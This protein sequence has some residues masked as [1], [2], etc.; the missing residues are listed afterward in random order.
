MNG[1]F[2]L[3]IVEA[4]PQG[5]EGGP[6]GIRCTNRAAT[7]GLGGVRLVGSADRTQPRTVLA[8]QR[9]V[10]QREKQMLTYERR[11]VQLVA[12]E[13]VRVG[14]GQFALV[15]LGNLRRDAFVYVTQTTPTT[16]VVGGRRGPPH[17]D[18]GV[19]RL[20]VE[21]DRNILRAD[22]FVVD[23]EQDGVD[24][25]VDLLDVA[26]PPQNLCDIDDQT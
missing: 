23:I 20:E 1:A 22:S 17:D 18:S 5:V 11:K 21:P 26:D 6:T 16:V 2:R 7:I 25:D 10:G 9:T 24:R 8:T 19:R 12:I 13:Q 15:Q 4:V 14:I 3:P